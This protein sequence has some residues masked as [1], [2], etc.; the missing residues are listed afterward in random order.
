MISHN[1]PRSLILSNFHFAD[2]HFLRHDLSSHPRQY[3]ASVEIEVPPLSFSEVAN[4]IPG[5]SG[6]QC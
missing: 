2:A 5:I 3:C 6:L 4:T 1:L